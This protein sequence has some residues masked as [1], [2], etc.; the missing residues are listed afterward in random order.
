ML[1]TEL[2]RVV[3]SPGIDDHIEWDTLLGESKT[4]LFPILLLCGICMPL[5]VMGEASGED[6]A[7][8]E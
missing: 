1:L 2:E 8:V 5:L 4:V 3:R 6:S 7:N